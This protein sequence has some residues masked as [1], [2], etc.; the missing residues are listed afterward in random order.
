MTED[1]ET[2]AIHAGEIPTPGLTGEIPALGIQVGN[3]ES[4]YHIGDP[5]FDGN[6]PVPG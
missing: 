5:G 2:P 3:I 1:I 4:G 6:I